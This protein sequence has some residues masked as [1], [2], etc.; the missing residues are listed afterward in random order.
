MYV[1]EY[2]YLKN[3]L[4]FIHKWMELINIPEEK[5]FLVQWR[6]KFWFPIVWNMFF[7]WIPNRREIGIKW[8]PYLIGA[9]VYYGNNPTCLRKTSSISISSTYLNFKTCFVCRD[10]FAL[11]SFCY[12]G[13]FQ[14]YMKLLFFISDKQ[15]KNG[16]IKYHILNL[17]KGFEE[18]IF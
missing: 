16:N 10:N 5:K 7:A 3:I 2:I 18:L 15:I 6:E 17:Q 1:L 13:I 8:V 14:W 9:F 11:I 4:Y 12:L